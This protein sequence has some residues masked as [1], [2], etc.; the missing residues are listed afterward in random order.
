MCAFVAWYDLIC[1]LWAHEAWPWPSQDLCAVFYSFLCLTFS[2]IKYTLKWGLAG[3]AWL[4][5][6]LNNRASN[7]G[8]RR[9]RE[10]FTITE[11]APTRAFSWL[12]APLVDIFCDRKTLC[13]LR[14]G[15][16]KGLKLY[17]II[18]LPQTRVK[19]EA[20]RKVWD[21][22]KYT[23]HYYTPHW[24]Q[25]WWVEVGWGVENINSRTLTQRPFIIQKQ[26]IFGSFE[27]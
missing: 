27:S 17:W 16:F 6:R 24:L 2:V 3:I 21:Q 25:W 18:I 19:Y 7:E 4:R 1:K 15:L 23:Q 10:D 11:K 8:S 9:L 13:N 12:K 20:R 26:K 5:L 22:N 14:E